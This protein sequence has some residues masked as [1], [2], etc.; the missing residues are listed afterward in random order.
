[1]KNYSIILLI[2]FS[3]LSIFS[4][5]KN[6]ITIGL[7]DNHFGKVTSCL[8]T[9]DE[10]NII[11]SDETGKIVLFDANKFEYVKTIRKSSGIPIHS[12]RLIKNDSLLLISQKYQYSDGTTD[13]IIG[14][15]LYD[16]KI[17]LKNKESFGFI[18]NTKKDLAIVNHKLNYGCSIEIIRNNFT[19][20]Y[21]FNNNENI[22]VLEISA[23]Q[24]KIIYVERDYV[25]QKNIIIKDILSNTIVKQIPIKEKTE[26]LHLIF[27]AASESF[28]ALCYLEEEHKIEVFKF[29]NDAIWNNSVFTYAYKGFSSS[30]LVSATA[31]NN[32]QNIVLTNNS[33]N[34]NPIIVQKRGDKFSAMEVELPVSPN[35]ALQIPSKEEIVFY[36][37]FNPNFSNAVA[38]NVYNAKTNKT[39]GE[40]P[41]VIK[42]ISKG[43]F[44]PND[45]WLVVGEGV[46][47]SV[48]Y[49]K[50]FNAGTFNNRFAKLKI[51]D[52]IILKHNIDGAG[53][54][55]NYGTLFDRVSG[56]Q[57]FY[58]RQKDQVLEGKYYYY[59]YDL[60]NDKVTQLFEDP[61]SYFNILDYN[62]KTKSL[63][64]SERKYVYN[65]SS[66]PSKIIVINPTKKIEFKDNYKNAKFSNN[67]DYLLTINS[68]NKVEIKNLASN[69]II[70]TQLL[71]DGGFDIQIAGDSGFIISHSLR[72][73]SL[74]NCYSQFIIFDVADNKVTSKVSDCAIVSDISYKNDSA[75]LIINNQI[76][77]V[78]DKTLNFNASETPLSVSFNSDASKV[79]ISFKTGIIKIYD[80]NTL[81]E[82]GAMIHPDKESH[83]FLDSNGYY[84]SNINA[85]DYLF[86]TQLNQKIA[87]QNIENEAF[88][89][90][91]I[92]SVFGKPNEEYLLALNKA[93]AIR[94][95]SKITT[96]FEIKP[97]GSKMQNEG[98]GK[99]NL[100]LISIGVSDYQQSNYNLTFADKDA[101]DIA[102]IYGKFDENEI[103][104]YKDKFF[105]NVF[106]LH[107]QKG[108]VV[109]KIKKSLGNI[110]KTTGDFFLANPKENKWLEI[111][112]DK[113][114]LWDFNTQTT[115]SLV[116][117][118]DYQPS[119]YD[120]KVYPYPDGT[121]FALRNID[122]VLNYSLKNK[123]SKISKLPTDLSSENYAFITEED[124]LVFDYQNDYNLNPPSKK[125]VLSFFNIA[126]NKKTEKAVVN[127]ANYKVKD[128][129]G[130]LNVVENEG[131]SIPYF[132]AVSPN[133]K[134]VLYTIDESP[135]FVDIAENN[136]VPLKIILDIK[137]ENSTS[138]S[139]SSDGKTFS[140]LKT[141]SEDLR[142]N[143]F[144]YTIDGKKTEN[145]SFTDKEY[146][147]KGFSMFD[148]KPR[149]VE[150]SA[151]LLDESWTDSNDNELLNNGQ[152]FSFEKVFVT[153]LV[154]KE[155][156][157]RTIKGTLEHFFEKSKK[158]DQVMIFLA[159]HGVLDKKNN[160]YFAPNDMDFTNVSTNGISFE[161]LVN[162]LKNAPATD[163]LLLMDSCHSGNTLDEIRTTSEGSAIKSNSDQ[164]GSTG[165]S[166]KEETNFKVSDIVTSLFENFLSTSG[167]TIISA[168]SGSDVAYENKQLGNGAFTAAYIKLLKDKLNSGVS[169]EKEE[170]QKS[171]PLTKEDISELFKQVMSSTKNKQVPDLREIN[172]K[173]ELKIW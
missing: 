109:G 83:V 36:Q 52:Y 142:Y 135:F 53:V 33:L 106:S 149:W 24:K 97:E 118:K 13:S 20:F 2:V 160:Y 15:R 26:V 164:R 21:T 121:G 120:M 56:F 4:Q 112:H 105:G 12:M 154:N 18:G 88:K 157:S 128:D 75:A 31:T 41:N 103:K 25:S 43:Y 98:L 65:T 132:K 146:A 124:W 96:D 95:G 22:D 123:K 28:F 148:A 58:G 125:I 104:D 32:D 162:S 29:K 101:K 115:D 94:N 110:Y 51:D 79:M 113:I 42:G 49:V 92:L 9:K 74:K 87:L 170:L 116:L 48:D 158:N 34:S 169:L 38:F 141:N 27:D 167:V 7:K 93:I 23:D 163:K 62:D 69:E 173:S 61:K 50:Y 119:I 85:E 117:P 68:L 46:N 102:Q 153:N 82:L 54:S 171:I 108:Q 67:G 6:P 130:K 10:K 114:N 8:L 134:Y 122:E 100:Y 19:S 47:G 151:P 138:M 57:I 156:N 1:M 63:L 81:K 143:T 133:G 140:V 139:I 166:T 77:G 14:I 126:T 137:I 111:N 35:I 76:V 55:A 3:A 152:P 86:A 5:E 17:V 165:N 37:N 144:V 60:I 129:K 45:N 78:K 11:T 72:K 59:I 84:F 107:E 155:A 99:P 64:L 70:Y 44:L 159:G 161:F 168:S 145:Q 40:F 89:P 172:D 80:A 39:I 30:T 90:E 71:E 131:Y 147:I 150:M 66:E 16:N 73:K 136:P 91:K 127:L